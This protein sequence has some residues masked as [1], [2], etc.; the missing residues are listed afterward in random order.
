M[1][2]ISVF[3]RMKVGDKVDAA[4]IISANS[5]AAY[6]ENATHYCDSVMSQ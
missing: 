2:N 3:A 1:S 5:S 6:N 4:K